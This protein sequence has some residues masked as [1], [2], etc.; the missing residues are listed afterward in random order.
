LG[1]F[2]AYTN[3]GPGTAL[4]ANQKLFQFYADGVQ[5][6]LSKSFGENIRAHTD[7]VF[8]AFTAGSSWAT[9]GTAIPQAYVTA[10]IPAGNGVEFL[11]GRFFVP[12]GY[13][14][15]FRNEN[16]TATHSVVFNVRPVTLTGIKFHYDFSELID[17]HVYAYN[18]MADSIGPGNVAKNLPGFGL[19]LGFNWGEEGK[20]NVVSVSGLA[21][22]ESAGNVA[23][24]T[25]DKMGNWTFLGDVSWNV[26]ATDTI[27]IGGEGLY[28]MD[29]ANKG[30]PTAKT[31]AAVVDLNYGFTDVWD[32]TLKLAY[33]HQN[34]SAATVG[35]LEAYNGIGG[36][37]NALGLRTTVMQGSFATQYQIADGAKLQA[38]FRLDW[39]SVP[40][41]Q[42]VAGT[43]KKWA[44]TYGP[45]VN[46]AYAF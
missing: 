41:S 10:N 8:G 44:M 27:T 18:S 23:G 35:S 3:A 46:F 45:I 33:A 40:S 39:G 24:G 1:E 12:F 30:T 21:G 15:L 42:Q 22:A 20:K 5:L 37:V 7:L 26:H 28:R 25:K 2:T 31:M 14:K 16:N 36:L 38:E 9:A 13:E 17:L 6:N 29:R 19:T 4:G 43:A 32:G 34:N 11:V